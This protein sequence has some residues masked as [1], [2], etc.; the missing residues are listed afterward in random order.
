[1]TNRDLER[2]ERNY[3]K[4][5]KKAID[6]SKSLDN[7]SRHRDADGSPRLLTRANAEATV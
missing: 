7:R 5:A 3:V 6:S 1:M 2:N 4:A